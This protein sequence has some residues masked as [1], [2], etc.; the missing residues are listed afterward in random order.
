MPRRRSRWLLVPAV[1]ILSTPYP[2]PAA[3]PPDL[4]GP[5]AGQPD[6]KARGQSVSTAWSV[7][8]TTLPLGESLTATL[9]VRGATN[10]REIVRPDLRQRKDFADRFEVEDLPGPAPAADAKE[11]SF[12]YRLKPRNRAVNRLP[13]LDFYFRKVG[14]D[15]GN[16][17][18]NARARGVDLSVTAPPAKA[19]PPPVPLAEPDHLFALPAGS[20]MLGGEAFAPD[21]G[22][23]VVLALAGPALAGGWF[24]AWRWKYPGAAR[25]ARLRRAR[26][27]RRAV[28]IIRRSHRTPEPAATVAAA[29]VGYLRSR[30]PLP[31]GTDTPAEVG[32][33][34]RA[35]GLP[36]D[37]A[38]EVVAF[39]RRCDAA[40]FGGS[41][42]PVSLDIGA[43][44]LLARLEAVE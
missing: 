23:W 10:P 42:T 41:D 3:Q 5:P 19:A 38:A 27:A 2:V 7:E 40:R 6:T 32:E 26:A 44:D 25:A 17:Y 11:V 33:A 37:P 36:D 29:V 20:E 24:A 16:P 14:I 39:L 4:F 12:A 9:T 15:K 31:P 28:S 22:A 1:L 43:V 13:S 34:V 30:F 18:Q 8:P 21:A 35:A